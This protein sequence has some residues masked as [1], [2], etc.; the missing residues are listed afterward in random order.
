MKTPIFLVLAC[1]IT[2]ASCDNCY[3]CTEPNGVKEQEICER[4]GK[5]KKSVDEAE[6]GGW[7]CVELQD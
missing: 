1:L 4:G 3:V 7:T 2:L 5:I 6:A